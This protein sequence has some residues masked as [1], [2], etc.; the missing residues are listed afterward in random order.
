[1]ARKEQVGEVAVHKDLIA[2]EMAEQAL[3]MTHVPSWHP[4]NEGEG[5]G[6]G[7]GGEGTGQGE[8][9]T[10]EDTR[11]DAEKAAQAAVDAAYEKLRAAEKERD[12]YKATA[13]KLERQGLGEVEKA[14][15]AAEDA[16]LEAAALQEKLDSIEREKVVTSVATTLKFKKPSI[17]LKFVE[18]GSTDEKSIRRDLADAIKDIPELVTEGAPPPPVNGGNQ[19]NNGSMNARMNSALRKAAGRA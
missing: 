3:W 1:M 19:N 8:G 15:R 9:G 16:R 4:R 2:A 14:Q 13:T 10:G 12:T 7:E 11:T 6:G 18:A 5:E 17:A